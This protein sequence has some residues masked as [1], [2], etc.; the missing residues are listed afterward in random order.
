M[1]SIQKLI[2]EICEEEQ[3]SFH[4][5]SKEWVLVLEKNG[6]THY[7]V[8]TRF[9]LN[10]YASGRICNDKYACFDALRYHHLPVCDHHIFYENDD[11]KEVEDYFHFCHD[12]VVVKANGGSYGDEVFHTTT[13]LELQEKMKFLFQS[14]NSLS[15]SPF[16]S[17]SCEY[18]VIV[19]DGE[20]LLI[21]G[22]QRPIVVGDGVHTIYELLCQFN[23]P[24]FE[25][26]KDHS[27]LDRVLETGKTFEYSWQHNISK[28][29]IPFLPKNPSL[30]Q[31]LSE[32]AILAT[33]KLN[34]RFVSVDIVL[35]ENQELKI[36]EINSGVVTNITDY[37]EDGEHL[38]KEIYRKAI[39]K[40]FN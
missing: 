1:T 28:G 25:K 3:I 35:L 32:I 2:Q 23:E 33:K 16:Y 24:F 36:L 8:G 30:E 14:N 40:M 29:A 10:N 18:R 38:A 21:F 34:L 17:I 6:E 26:L 39:L 11:I 9:D 4:T 19:L 22:K 27:S 7:I 31:K 15:I 12:D 37:L 13:F 5:I 20:V